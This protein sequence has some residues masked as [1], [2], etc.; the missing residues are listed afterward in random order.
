[1]YLFSS[2][3][4][5]QNMVYAQNVETQPE[6]K[7]VSVRTRCG[8]CFADQ[9]TRVDSH[10][11]SEG[12]LWAFLCFCFGSWII[13]IVILCMDAFKE[14]DHVC[15]SCHRYLATYKPKLTGGN[16]ATLV[17]LTICLIVLQVVLFIFVLLPMIHG[18]NTQSDSNSY[19]YRG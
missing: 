6:F 17:L 12:W 15:S 3:I 13:S 5:T 2:G 14:W 11:S 19:S 16:I 4:E 1:M 8:N 18:T 7:K 10:I 9:Y